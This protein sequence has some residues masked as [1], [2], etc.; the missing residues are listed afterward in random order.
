MTGELMSNVRA[1]RFMVAQ[2]RIRCVH[3]ARQTPVIALA[4]LPGHE[5]LD[6]EEDELWIPAQCHA[7]LFYLTALPESVQRVLASLPGSFRFVHSAVTQ[8]RY[9]ANHCAH[10]GLLIEDHDLHGEPSGAFVPMTASDA[11]EVLLTPLYA[12]FEAQA[13]GYAF[14]PAFFHAMRVR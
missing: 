11:A 9:W 8:T 12:P 13:E 14:E 10:C 7:F 2:R 5:C 1:E 3:C 4:L 6:P